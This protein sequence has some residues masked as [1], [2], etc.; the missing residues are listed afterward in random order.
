MKKLAHKIDSFFNRMV[1]AKKFFILFLL[2][3][4]IPLIVQNAVY[5][6]QT[7]W[8]IQEEILLKVNEGM[9][10][11]ADRINGA[12]SEVLFMARNYERNEMLYEWLDYEYSS[13]MEFLIQYQETI[14]KFFMSNVSSMSQIRG[15]GIYT[16]NTTLFNNYYA[17]NSS[18]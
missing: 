6:W 3:A 2:G 17:K 11:K 5:Y 16:E 8:K 14:Q 15:V 7:E 10:D 12:L 4:A 1:F 18:F 13:E 9:D